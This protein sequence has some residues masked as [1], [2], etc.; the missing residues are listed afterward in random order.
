[1]KEIALGGH[2][3]GHW[4]QDGGVIDQFEHH[5]RAVGGWPLGDGTRHS[6]VEM[7]DLIGNDMLKLDAL[8]AQPAT[9]IHLY[10][11]TETRP[12]RKM[13]HVNRIIQN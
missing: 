12:G 2:C 10:G 4:T 3:S 13:G 5:I 1:V 7:E 9:A 6:D 11:K 8:R